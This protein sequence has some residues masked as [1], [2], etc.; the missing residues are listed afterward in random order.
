MREPQHLHPGVSSHL[1]DVE[2]QPNTGKGEAHFQKGSSH[3]LDSLHF[4]GGPG[5]L[6]FASTIVRIKPVSF[7]TR[8]VLTEYEGRRKDTR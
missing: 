3:G 2:W 7:Q 6:K 8:S 4:G 5:M 1:G